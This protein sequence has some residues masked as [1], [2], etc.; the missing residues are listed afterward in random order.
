MEEAIAPTFKSLYTKVLLSQGCHIS[1]IAWLSD[2]S[3]R[4]Y[5]GVVYLR[6]ENS[7]G[8][9]HTLLVMSKTR[10]APINRYT[11]P[12]LELCRALVLAQLLSHCKDILN[13]PM[14]SIFAWTDS[15]IM[16]SW[17]QGN[18]RRFKVYVAHRLW[19]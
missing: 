1:T 3:E 19:I 10:V 18:P 13:I 15:T 16:L 4:A 8:T 5:S 6:M 9:V 11:I 17:L 14:Q 7:S 2:A 12:R